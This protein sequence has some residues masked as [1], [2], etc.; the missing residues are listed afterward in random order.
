MNKRRK[1]EER[2]GQE[3]ESGEAVESSVI[4]FCNVFLLELLNVCLCQCVCSA[5]SMFC[6]I[7]AC[8]LGKKVLNV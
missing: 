6:L 7:C 4:V 5:L 2:E 1:R 3:E 8:L